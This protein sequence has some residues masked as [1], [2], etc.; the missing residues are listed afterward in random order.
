MDAIITIENATRFFVK[1][2]K[3]HSFEDKLF[4]NESKMKNFHNFI[5]WCTIEGTIL[6]I[7][8]I[9]I[10][11][12]TQKFEIDY[13]ILVCLAGFILPFF[14]NYLFQ[15]FV[16]EK[17]K[18]E[19]EELL[20]DL[21]LE[22]SVFCDESSMER[23]IKRI[24]TQEMG[25]VSKDFARAYNEIKN[26]S[27]IEEAL[28]RI[29]ILNKSK[30]YNR[31]IDLLLQGYKSGA[32]IS[33]TLK[34]T[35]ED[36]LESKAIIKERQAVMLVTKYT[37]L[38]AAGIIVPA[39]LGL[40]VGLVSG[41]NF[42]SIGEMS[43]G[44]SVEMRKELFAS[45]INGT[46]IYIFEYALLS[47]FFLALQEGNKKNFWFYSLILVPVSTIVFFLAKSMN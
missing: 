11:L 26:G 22:A 41:L 16:F 37:L 46:T 15:D 2:E 40:I 35:A 19:K 34:E 18:R 20:S 47:S 4:L 32:R 21:L 28:L 6:M 44:L 1:E 13:L 10:F 29:K 9:I 7:L 24:S 36:L 17:R 45:A 8:L 38:L 39:I 30:I 25:G 23:T 33:D 3:I 27:S 5:L 14:L 12:E 43:L 31:V 42:S